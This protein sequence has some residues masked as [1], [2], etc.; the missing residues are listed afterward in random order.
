MMRGFC[1]SSILVVL[2]PQHG[3]GVLGGGESHTP[4]R[5]LR[6]ACVC[7]VSIVTMRCA[8]RRG[9]I[10]GGEMGTVVSCL[11]LES[12]RMLRACAV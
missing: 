6:L 3:R 8:L 7:C 1:A 9:S 2:C 4:K 12:R 10:F 11:A 5:S